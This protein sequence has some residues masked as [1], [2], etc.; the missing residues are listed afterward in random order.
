MKRHWATVCLLST[1]NKQSLKWKLYCN[2][3]NKGKNT[4]TNAKEFGR[5]LWQE[6]DM[7][8]NYWTSIV[9]YFSDF[10]KSSRNYVSNCFLDKNFMPL[11]ILKASPNAIY[12]TQFADLSK[13]FIKYSGCYL[14]MN[15]C[16]YFS[17]LTPS[18]RIF[19]NHFQKCLLQLGRLSHKLVE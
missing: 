3:E 7:N 6:L 1:A 4:I 16:Q 5:K 14:W 18:K 11:Q 9:K 12:V 2:E 13:H 17:R 8:N 10:I 19:W 15:D